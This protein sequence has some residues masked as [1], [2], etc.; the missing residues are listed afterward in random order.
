MEFNSIERIEKFN[1]STKEQK[2]QEVL[3]TKLINTINKLD[4]K[5]IELSILEKLLNKSQCIQ[6]ISNQHGVGVGNYLPSTYQPGVPPRRSRLDITRDK[7]RKLQI[8]KLKKEILVLE[9]KL[10]GK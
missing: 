10:K 7:N 4:E 1:F 6:N 3:A 5:R 2:Y 8:E 9:K